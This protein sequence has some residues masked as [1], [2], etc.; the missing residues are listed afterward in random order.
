[1]SSEGGGEVL[2]DDTENCSVVDKQ[3]VCVTKFDQSKCV[4]CSLRVIFALGSTV[5]RPTLG[6]LVAVILG[7]LRR[8]KATLGK[9][10]QN[11]VRLKA[12]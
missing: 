2:R 7:D 5:F 4:I 3:A 11:V 1:M 8:F 6:P 12:I 9:F 10:G